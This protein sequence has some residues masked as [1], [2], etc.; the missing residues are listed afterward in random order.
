MGCSSGFSRL[1]KDG[2]GKLGA[3]FPLRG[4]RQGGGSGQELATRTSVR[5]GQQV[6]SNYRENTA[7]YS[8]D[9]QKSASSGGSHWLGTLDLSASTSRVL[10]LQACTTTTPGS[11]LSLRSQ[12]SQNRQDICSQETCLSPH[13]PLSVRRQI[14]SCLETIRSLAFHKWIPVPA[15]ETNVLICMQDKNNRFG[16]VP[17]KS[18]SSDE[19][20][21]KQGYKTKNLL[22]EIGWQKES[23]IRQLCGFQILS[24]VPC[25]SYGKLT[26][27]DVVKHVVT[28]Q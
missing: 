4:R 1:E 12:G 13:P 21:R 14:S 16:K 20:D 2:G 3:Q 23:H 10:E 11:S 9:H 15:T 22:R 5:G 18:N 27:P 26:N 17:K 25:Q 28:I 24:L 19:V 7:F 8:E 6:K